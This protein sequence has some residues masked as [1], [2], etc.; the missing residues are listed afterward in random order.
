[1]ENG[2]CGRLLIEKPLSNQLQEA[3]EFLEFAKDRGLATH[4]TI[5]YS[6]RVA[7]LY[8]ELF[9]MMRSQKVPDI[10][11]IDVRFSG[12]L[13][14]KGSH[15][16]DIMIWF[17]G[18]LPRSVEASLT[19][20]KSTNRRGAAKTEPAGELQLDFGSGRRAGV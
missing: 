2:F 4:V 10:R 1:M 5:D 14:M 9:S 8:N 15:F 16:L 20:P 18:S 17:F 13:S 19:Y 11:R 3:R 7:K 12:T 6:R